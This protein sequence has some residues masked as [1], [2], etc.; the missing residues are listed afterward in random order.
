MSEICGIYE[1]LV[2]VRGILAVWIRSW[3]GHGEG[4]GLEELE[5]TCGEDGPGCYG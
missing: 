3:S 1:R 4:E 5:T 2:W